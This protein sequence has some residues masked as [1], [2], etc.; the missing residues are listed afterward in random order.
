MINYIVGDATNPIGDGNKIIV[1]CCNNVG[2][3]GRGFVK[4]LSDKFPKSEHMYREW[5]R[6]YSD[7]ES[8]KLEPSKFEYKYNLDK[9]KC[10][11][12]FP[13]FKLGEVQFVEVSD[14]ICVANLIGQEGI[15]NNQKKPPIRYNAI[16]IGFL[17]VLEFALKI[18]KCSIHMPYIG[19]GLA[20][21][22]LFELNN[23]LNKVFLN[24]IDVYV[25]SFEDK[26]SESYIPV[27]M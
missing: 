1:H 16:E 15:L 25:Y 20:G 19:C 26:N 7:F 18:E 9:I 3:W 13:R 23:I 24:K 11:L 12:L 14:D 17:K 27:N 21:G 5:F 8:S 10:N 6:L 2:A 4:A 22:T